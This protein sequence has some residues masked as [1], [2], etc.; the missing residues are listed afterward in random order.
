[1]ED[2]DSDAE[3]ADYGTDYSDDVDPSLCVARHVHKKG[4]QLSK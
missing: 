1:M 3:M 4:P 2:D